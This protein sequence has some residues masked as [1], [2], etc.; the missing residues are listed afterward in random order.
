MMKIDTNAEIMV[1]EEIMVEEA[2]EVAED[3]ITTIRVEI[4]V[5][6]EITETREVDEIFTFVQILQ[7]ILNLVCMCKF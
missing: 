7:I 3:T 5:V 4:M 6:E 2:T 1:V